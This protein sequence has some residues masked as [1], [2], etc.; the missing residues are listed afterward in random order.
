MIEDIKEARDFINGKL[1]ETPV[2]GL[3]EDDIRKFL[4][5]NSSVSIKLELFQV[6][7][8]LL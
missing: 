6:C 1:V 8:I 3:K 4:P 5:K 7:L 2:L